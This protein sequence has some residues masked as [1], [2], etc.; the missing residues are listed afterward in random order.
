MQTDLN[1]VV[2]FFYRLLSTLLNG[3]MKYQHVKFIR[4]EHHC[5]K[6]LCVQRSGQVDDGSA[7]EAQKTPRSK[8]ARDKSGMRGEGFGTDCGP[9]G[10]TAR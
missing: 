6:N 10:A 9:E 4:G 7:K 2:L 3:R 8:R 5:Y 1:M